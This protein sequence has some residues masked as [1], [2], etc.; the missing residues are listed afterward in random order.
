MHDVLATHALRMGWA[1]FS[2]HL[3]ELDGYPG[4]VDDASS[5]IRTA[6]R[7][8][9]WRIRDSSVAKPLDDYEGDEYD[10][11]KRLVRLDDGR[12][13]DAWLYLYRGPVSSGIVVRYGDWVR[14]LRERGHG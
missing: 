10:R 2:G 5:P 9:V 7:G 13:L 6:V 11:V 1:V 8:E 14:M 3:I 4:L 12:T